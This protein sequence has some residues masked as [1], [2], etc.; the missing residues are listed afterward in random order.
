MALRLLPYEFGFFDLFEKQVDLAIEGARLLAAFLDDLD[1]PGP[2]AR[3]IK[4]VEH[5]ADVVTH[6]AIELL[7]KTFVTPFDRDEIHR[8][9][10]QLDD[11]IDAMEASSE[12]IW[13][14]EIAVATPEARTL[15]K[16]LIEATLQLK[17]AVHGL[18]HVKRERGR[19]L[20]ACVEVNRLENANDETLREGLAKLF[21]GERDAVVILKWKEIYEILEQATDRCEDVANVLEGVVLE[22]E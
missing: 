1:S 2:K 7:H 15:A 20:A 17:V 18:R 8:L 3:R 5:E 12:R 6:Q 21:K 4:E 22:N 11:V 9:M 14:Y 13:L 19:I 10:S 16:N